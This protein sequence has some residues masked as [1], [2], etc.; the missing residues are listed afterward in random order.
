M[1]ASTDTKGDRIGINRF[2]R[3]IRQI[4]YIL[5]QETCLVGCSRMKKKR[6]YKSICQIN[7]KNTL[8]ISLQKRKIRYKKSLNTIRF[9]FIIHMVQQRKQIRIACN[10]RENRI[11]FCILLTFPLDDILG[12]STKIRKR[13]WVS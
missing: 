13:A 1:N 4:F 12:L 3:S 5:Y 11:V 9:L 2:T 8:I 10:N 7:L 6:K